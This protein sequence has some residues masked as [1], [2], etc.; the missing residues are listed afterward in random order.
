MCSSVDAVISSGGGGKKY[1]STYSYY[2][3]TT[4]KATNCYPLDKTLS[5]KQSQKQIGKPEKSNIFSPRYDNNVN[6]WQHL[7]VTLFFH[8]L[9]I[10]SSLVFIST[11][12]KT[13][14]YESEFLIYKE[15]TFQVLISSYQNN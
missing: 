8:L 15:T 14:H 10:S 7:M 11:F 2:D 3:M 13:A 6:D 9:L 1:N 12:F 4:Q 5:N